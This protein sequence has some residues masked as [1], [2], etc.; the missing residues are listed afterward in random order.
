MFL[1][2]FCDSD[3]WWFLTCLMLLLIKEWLV[4]AGQIIVKLLGTGLS[5]R[6]S[7]GFFVYSFLGRAGSRNW[8]RCNFWSWWEFL[9]LGWISWRTIVVAT[10]LDYR[11]IKK[12]AW[13]KCWNWGLLQLDILSMWIAWRLFLSQK[14]FI[15]ALIAQHS[16]IIV[17]IVN[18]HEILL[19][20][21]LCDL[22]RLSRRCHF[23][24]ILRVIQS[25]VV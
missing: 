19:C 25:R 16:L 10:V 5:S 21:R 6:I 2:L 12:L 11:F 1:Y 22:L 4:S 9:F 20:Y 14:I 13:L 15:Q 8:V 3:L 23:L 18:G 24:N 17:N 7:N